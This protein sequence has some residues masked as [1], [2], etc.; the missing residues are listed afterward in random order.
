MDISKVM[1]ELADKKRILGD[2]MKCKPLTGGT[3][4]EI[5][6]LSL[7]N[8]SNFVIK[9]N[10]PNIVKS[11]AEFLDLYRDIPLLPKLIYTDPTN[12][13]IIYSYIPGATVN[14]STHNKKEIL[15]EIVVGLLNNYKTISSTNGWGWRDSPIDSWRNFLLTEVK[16]ASEVLTDHLLKVDVE[17]VMALIMRA[18][19]YE[20]LGDPFLIHGDCGIHNFIM[21]DGRLSG[22]IDP[23]PVSGPP[24]YDLI[25]A[26]C[27]SPADLTKET[28]NS[29]AS[30]LMVQPIDEKWLYEEVAIVL[31]L[32]LATCLKHHPADFASYL[33]AWKYWKNIILSDI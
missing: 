19:R 4:S 28:L 33:A 25:Y 31:Y 10:E 9:S 8:G 20:T 13:Y 23:T 27:S 26:F 5:Y 2:N 24:H 12:E 11:E 14:V 22:V 30:L 17:S 29:A 18:G 32:R 3:V 7:E 1:K 15:Q 16:G 21:E 6:L